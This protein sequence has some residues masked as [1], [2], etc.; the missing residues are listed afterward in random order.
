[1]SKQLPTR[2]YRKRNRPLPYYHSLE[3]YTG[4]SHNPT[5]PE[6]IK[7]CLIKNNKKEVYQQVK[8]LT[9]EKNGRATIV[10][11]MSRKFYGRTRDY[12]QMYRI[13]G[14]SVGRY[15]S[16]VFDAFVFIRKQSDIFSEKI[17]VKLLFALATNTNFTS[18]PK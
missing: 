17:R 15:L 10:Q 7:T 9:L 13:G 2:T 14:E 3:V 6:K 5:T 16:Q 12:Q 4:P 11:D 8:D 18:P 1:M